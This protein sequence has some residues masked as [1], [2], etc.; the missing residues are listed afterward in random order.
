MYLPTIFRSFSIQPGIKEGF[1]DPPYVSNPLLGSFTMLLDSL[2]LPILMA[3]CVVTLFVAIYSIPYMSHRFHEMEQEE[4][5][6]PSW[7]TYYS[8]YLM[9]SV[10]MLGTVLSANLVEFY[11]FLE[12]TLVPSFLLI[13]FYGYGARVRIA[14]LYFIWTHVGALLFLIGIFLTGLNVGTFDLVNLQRMSLNYGVEKLIPEGI[15]TF[16]LLAIVIGLMVKLAAFG[17][18]I[19]LP[20]AHA[21][22]PTPISALLSPNL[23][24]IAGYAL[25][26]IAITLFPNSFLSIS[27]YLILW[28][29]LTMI[30]GGLMALA[31][32]DFKRLLAYSSVSQMGYVLLGVASMTPLGISGAMLHYVSHAVGKALLFM[33]AGNLIVT[34]NGL[35]SIGK[36]GGVARKLPLTASLALVGFLHITG[37]PPSLGFWSEILTIMGAMNRAMSMGTSIYVAMIVGLLTAI[38]LSTIYAF[39]TMKRIF[40]GEEGEGI[41]GL[42]PEELRG[43]VLPMILIAAFGVVMFFYPSLLVDPLVSLVKSVYFAPG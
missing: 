8:M 25:V 16:V 5:H 40:Y 33:T 37:V 22:A 38:G 3:I 43:L 31:Q 6:P 14:I 34:F 36:M 35:R 1:V 30:Y 39:L 21:E 10:A 4:E 7:S 24:G 27:P 28:A 19:W 9:F 17:V 15:R 29:L 26:R 41:S 20:Y 23:I 11:V 32:D 12:L 18:H 13:A 2:N 42:K